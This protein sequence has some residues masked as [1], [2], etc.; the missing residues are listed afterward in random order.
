MLLTKPDEPEEFTSLL[1]RLQD[2]YDHVNMDVRF[3]H[4]CDQSIY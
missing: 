4:A 2:V 1:T 3:N